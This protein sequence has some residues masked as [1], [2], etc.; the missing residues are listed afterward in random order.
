MIL[1]ADPITA[2]FS[3]GDRCYTSMLLKSNYC[4]FGSGYT[5]TAHPRFMC[6]VNAFS[7][8]AMR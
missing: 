2:S 6:V 7:M 5:M 3:D 8:L 1:L 4:R